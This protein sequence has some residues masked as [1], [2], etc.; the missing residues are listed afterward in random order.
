MNYHLITFGCQ[1][2]EADSE[3]IASTLES[4]GYKPSLKNKADLILFNACSV[5][6]SAIN[7][8]YGLLGNIINKGKN[9]K[10]PKIIITGCIL[11]EDRKKFAQKADMFFNIKDLKQLPRILQKFNKNIAF[12]PSTPLAQQMATKKLSPEEESYLEIKPKYKNNF[13]AL[14]PISNGCNKFCAY[15]AV[16][17]ARGIEVSRPAEDVINEIE[18][19]VKNGYKEITLLGQTVNSYSI[20]M[21]RSVI[22]TSGHPERSEGSRRSLVA[23]APQDDG[24]AVN[25][26]KLLRIINAIPGKFWIRFMSPYP[27]EFTNELIQTMAE[28]GKINNYTNLPVQSGDNEILRKMNRRYTI[29]EYKEILNKLRKAIPGIAISTDVIVGFPGEAKKQFQNTAKLFKKLKFDMAYI[30][31]YSPRPGTV[32]AKAFKDDVPHKEK[33]RRRKILTEIL[34]KTALE[35]NKKYIGKTV[36]VLVE[37]HRNGVNFG[38]TKSF[39]NVM[40]AADK[41]LV[42]NFVKIKI[43]KAREWTLEGKLYAK[44]D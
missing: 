13:Q 2:N 28:C 43:K 14:V 11:E 12:V 32:S 22:S 44:T 17:Y 35:N 39:K 16:P 7:R 15:C 30:A 18:G 36:E 25:F 41:N 26:A 9:K 24:R 40:F 19:L 5:R 34:K 1:A 3:R 38:K 6:Q 20:K 29:D 27:T 33:E 42:G 37:R 23:C 8:I 4:L 31:E 10:K 21:T